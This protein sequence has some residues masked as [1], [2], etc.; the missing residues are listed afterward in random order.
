MTT[1]LLILTLNEV[2]G[3]KKIMPLVKREW[4]DELIVIDGGS[5]DGTIEE[6]KKMG[7]KVLLQ[8]NKGYGAA[9]T[10][11]VEVTKSDN[12]VLSE[13]SFEIFLPLILMLTVAITIPLKIIPDVIDLLKLNKR[14]TSTRI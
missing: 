6:A 12:I 2:D 8:K 4:V 7:L 5:T 1:A 14:N 13:T 10:L 9:V 3:I 11:G